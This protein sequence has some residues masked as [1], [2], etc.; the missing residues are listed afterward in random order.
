MDCFI[1]IML[2]VPVLVVVLCG[3]VAAFDKEGQHL[4]FTQ[5]VQHLLNDFCSCKI[6]KLFGIYLDLYLNFLSLRSNFRN[7][8]N[9]LQ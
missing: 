2:V 8:K 3:G 7:S 5:R 4:L 6:V 9:Q 1:R